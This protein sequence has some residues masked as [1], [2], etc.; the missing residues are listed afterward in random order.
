MFARD[1]A[2]PSPSHSLASVRLADHFFF[3]AHADGAVHSFDADEARHAHKA[4]RLRADDGLRWVD[5]KG[6]RFAGRLKSVG[7]KG[8][9]A[10]VDVAEQAPPTPT[11]AL[12]VGALH[13]AARLEWL[14]EKAVELGAT[15]ITVLRTERVERPRHRMPRLVAKAVAAMKQS[16]RALL[17]RLSEAEFATFIAGAD[18]PQR[19]VAHCEAA[20]DRL[21]VAELPSSVWQRGCTVLVGPEGDFT[22]REIERA[23]AA[24]F[25]E[26]SLGSA[27]L[28]TET[29]ALAILAVASSARTL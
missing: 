28:R 24:G 23:A 18:T 19:L 8:M 3:S 5:G 11:L 12:G 9:T 13:D 16:G 1:L 15:E 4:L 10:V 17:P 29:A 14:V 22:P 2:S 25:R 20:R 26:L 6:G 27:R 7:P 21:A